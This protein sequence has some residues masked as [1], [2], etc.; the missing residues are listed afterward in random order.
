MRTTFTTREIESPRKID[1]RGV[2]TSDATK[3]KWWLVSLGYLRAP[4]EL[5]EREKE[6]ETHAQWKK[7]W[8][9]RIHSIGFLERDSA[10]VCKAHV[11][12]HI[13]DHSQSFVRRT[14]YKK[15]GRLFPKGLGSGAAS[16]LR[17]KTWFSLR[18]CFVRRIRWTDEHARIQR[19]IE[20][21][22][23]NHDRVRRAFFFSFFLTCFFFVFFVL[24][25]SDATR[26]GTTRNPVS[27]DSSAYFIRDIPSSSFLIFL[28]FHN[29]LFIRAGILFSRRGKHRGL[30]LVDNYLSLNT[31]R[32]VAPPSR[33][34]REAAFCSL[35]HRARL[36]PRDHPVVGRRRAQRL[37]HRVLY[38]T[39]HYN[40]ACYNLGAFLSVFAL[41]FRSFRRPTTTKRTKTRTTTSTG[42]CVCF[43][44]RM[45]FRFL[46]REVK[47]VTRRVRFFFSVLHFT[48]ADSQCLPVIPIGGSRS[49]CLY[50]EIIPCRGRRLGVFCFF[51]YTFRKA[52][53]RG[54][55]SVCLEA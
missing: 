35:S 19:T 5:R 3:G 41:C 22:E 39:S 40:T 38:H 7:E 49:P 52:P 33:A 23:G 50:S 25:P 54:F 4:A 27:L 55:A 45:F 21:H 34:R 2:V 15:R 8:F 51:F 20:N 17:K 9:E 44:S 16:L 53:A 30:Y 13:V 28:F 37:Y 26:G 36:P 47:G 42:L 31:P 46:S 32:V 29:F 48:F 12:A 10:G 14:L 6:R 1:E 18:G 11:A 43:V 24:E